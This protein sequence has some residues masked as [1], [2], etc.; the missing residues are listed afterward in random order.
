MQPSFIHLNV[1]SEY[2]ICDGIIRIPEL[3]SAAKQDRMP[4][5]ALTDPVNLFGSIK[6]YKEALKQG[7]KPLIGSELWL[8]DG[9]EI[10]N[11]ICLCMNQTGYL[12]LKKLI[13][14]GYLTGQKMNKPL[15]SKLALFDLNQGLIVLHGWKQGPLKLALQKDNGLAKKQLAPWLEAFSG[16]FYLE[17]QQ[18]DHQGE[19]TLLTQTLAF[20]EA[21]K[22]PA[23]ASNA[24]CFL[25]ESDFHAHEAR[26]CINQGVQLNDPSRK[27]THTQAQF[28]KTQQAM[29]NLFQQ[30]PALLANSVIIAQRCNLTIALGTP[31][32][33]Q[34]QAPGQQ[35][36]D[37]YFEQLS[38]DSLKKR[39]DQLN[40]PKDQHDNYH[41]RLRFEID[42]IRKMGFPSYFLIVADFIGWAKDNNIPVGPGR[43][44]GSGSLVAYSLG[45]TDLDPIG[46]EL[47]FE[48]FLNPERVSMPDFDIDFCMDRRDDVIRYVMEKYGRDCVSQIITFGRMAAKAVVRDIGRVLGH[49][50]GF[51]DK[52][53]K[54]IPFDLGMTLEKA[55]ILEP[56]L[57]ARYQDEEEVRD[58]IDLAKKLE[59]ITRNAGKHAGG[60]VIAPSTLTD[61]TAL[62]CEEDGSNLVT[63]LD[64][65]DVEAAGLVKFDFLG[66]RTLTIIQWAVDSINHR[67]KQKDA[68]A[69]PLDIVNIP[70]NDAES[71]TLLKRCSTTA[72]FQ[73]ESRGMKELISRLQP[74]SFEEITALVALFRPGPLQSGM[75]DD[76]I[77][78]K[79]GR[80]A[81]AYPH[82]M[83]ESILKPTYGVILYQEQVMQIAQK[84]SGYSLGEADLLRR[85]MGKK[86]PEEM[87]KQRSSFVTGATK[88]GIEENL[89]GEIFDIIEKF[90][91][92]GFNR[93]HS[94]AYALIAYQTAWL[95]AHYPTHFMA[96]VLSS[97]MDNTDKVVTFI[98]ECQSMGIKLI[99]PSIYK[100]L[101]HFHV[102][103]SNQIIFGLGAIKGVGENAIDAIISARNEHSS[104]DS[105]FD[106]CQ[107]VDCRKMNRKALESLV[108]SGALDDFGQHRASLF[109]SIDTALQA[110][111]QQAKNDAQGQSDLFGAC[112][113][114]PSL[115]HTYAEVPTWLDHERLDGEKQTLGFYQSG[116]PVDAYLHDLTKLT[117]KPLREINTHQNKMVTVA[118]IIQQCKTRINKKGRKMAFL[119]LE[120][121][122]GSVEI[123][124]F[125]DV[126]PQAEPHLNSQNIIL[127]HGEASVDNYTGNMSIQAKEVLAFDDARSIAAK[128]IILHLCPMENWQQAGTK[129]LNDILFPYKSGRCPV[130]LNL[131]NSHAKGKMRLGAQWDVSLSQDLLTQLQETPMIE[132]IEIVY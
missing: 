110:A 57:D 37:T 35:N 41:N 70:T 132:R 77:D 15:V 76:F 81:I 58:L 52:I 21:E 13:S 6:F 5:V 33:P 105:L 17:V 7:I 112:S 50:Y 84:L 65:D 107:K 55:L 103:D 101:K 23:V 99:P 64:K 49:P 63:Q 19:A 45:I 125:S 31:C 22:I 113:Q 16:R 118:G 59:G 42:I 127:I 11:I 24:V 73:L 54:L 43:G 53:A 82:P 10:S 85:A 115:N 102:N 51:V 61:F 116:H 94:A 95:K 60:V 114:A 122:T 123:A 28:F 8:S 104:F 4:A 69:E 87:A 93:S 34:F 30:N 117:T 3:I 111:D 126:F 91:G 74:D 66:L 124:I 109:A 14:N 48:R 75:V 129:R 39:L 92:Y 78:R 29:T 44:S 9:D 119:T 106:L 83:L 96:A 40:T 27:R 67:R 25:Q 90:A 38:K 20:A 100:S 68:K 88:N 97:D 86:K 36:T 18:I 62:Y 12:N 46:H 47:L 56:Q 79:H 71:F 32:L 121:H 128:A 72:V 26:V 98:D 1:H 80:A 130:F 2:A 89:A 131:I 120:D 108:K